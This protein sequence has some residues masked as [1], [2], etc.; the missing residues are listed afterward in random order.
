MK[1]SNLCN[2]LRDPGFSYTNTFSVCYVLDSLGKK[3]KEHRVLVLVECLISEG[4]DEGQVN[5]PIWLMETQSQR[6]SSKSY[7]GPAEDGKRASP[8][9]TLVVI[10][11][12][13]QCF[14]GKARLLKVKSSLYINIAAQRPLSCHRN[15]C[16]LFANSFQWR[17]IEISIKRSVLDFQLCHSLAVWLSLGV[18]NILVKI[19]YVTRVLWDKRMFMNI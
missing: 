18:L 2:K 9:F 14:L 3:S 4:E 7:W 8:E 10:P 11:Q 1:S 17:S 5:L 15:F 16:L 6:I 19:S 12:H 13:L